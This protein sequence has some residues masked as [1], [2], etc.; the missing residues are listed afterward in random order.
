MSKSWQLARECW[1]LPARGAVMGIL[2][3]TPDSFS[4]GGQHFSTK[5]ALAHALRM[6]DEGADLIDIGGES[7]RPGADA[8]SPSEEADRVLP[9]IEALHRE[10]PDARISVD[11]RHPEVAR[12]A[13]KSGA[14]IVNDITGLASPD[15]RRVCAELPCGVILMHMQGEPKTMQ[16]NP[17]YTDVVAEVREFFAA[18]VQAAEQDG[19][20]RNRICLDPGIG[21]GKNVQHNLLLIRHLEQ[22]RVHDL[23]MLMALSR[24][25]FM[26]AILE[27]PQTPKISPLP[28][29]V[30][31]L[32][33]ADAGAE[34]HRVHDVAP[35]VQA[36]RLRHACLSVG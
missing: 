25:R 15:M 28:T 20:T 13:L 16:Q 22:T 17:H 32:L 36:L 34:L 24:K 3:V 7:T 1:T 35:L 12:A 21:F 23:P 9:V 27:D 19:I 14:D 18:R 8:V 4:D 29:V 31:S 5:A 11:T 10:R 2:N 26:G 33:A 30:M 6:L